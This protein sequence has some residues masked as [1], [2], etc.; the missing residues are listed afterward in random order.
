MLQLLQGHKKEE[1]YVFL[2]FQIVCQKV[3]VVLSVRLL[4]SSAPSASTWAADGG[5]KIAQCGGSLG[6]GWEEG[7]RGSSSSPGQAWGKPGS[8]GM[9]DTA[10]GPGMSTGAET[11]RAEGGAGSVQGAEH[12]KWSRERAQPSFCR[13]FLRTW[14]KGQDSIVCLAMTI[15]QQKIC[16]QCERNWLQSRMFTSP[17]LLLRGRLKS[18]YPRKIPKAPQ[19]LWSG[20]KILSLQMQILLNK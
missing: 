16:K 14:Q 2:S 13:S 17:I 18:V 7:N 12:R 1:I 6:A 3:S 5:I 9:L 20:I 8:P 10:P 4:D 15:K 11:K 19:H